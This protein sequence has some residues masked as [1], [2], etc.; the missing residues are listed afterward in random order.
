MET[1]IPIVTLFATSV[2]FIIFA[3]VLS[4]LALSHRD[5]ESIGPIVGPFFCASLIG[6]P[7]ASALVFLHRRL[8]A[9]ER[10]GAS[11][12]QTLGDK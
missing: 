6:L 5:A 8:S 2:L 4:L 10:R 1:K 11:N 12:D 7:A 3:L 9:L